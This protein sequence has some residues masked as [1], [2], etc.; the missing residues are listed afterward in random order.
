MCACLHPKPFMP[1]AIN[2]PCIPRQLAAQ[3]SALGAWL[4]SPSTSPNDSRPIQTP[5]ATGKLFNCVNPESG[6]RLDPDY[7][8]PPGETL[9]R[10]VR[11]VCSVAPVEGT[12]MLNVC[13][14]SHRL[15][16]RLALEI[17]PLNLRLLHE[18]TSAAPLVSLVFT[19]W[20]A[21]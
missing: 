9:T 17:R 7:L 18:R 5:V 6:D 2:R 15:A 21:Q 16:D 20:A 8:L 3:P 13:P 1:T 10:E 12:I 11:A 14:L 4:A 19:H